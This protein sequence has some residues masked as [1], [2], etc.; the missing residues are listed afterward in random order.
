MAEGF[1]MVAGSQPTFA[2]DF[3]DEIAKL[4]VGTEITGSV[5]T[6]YDEDDADVTSTVKDADGFSTTQGR[7]RIKSTAPAGCYE[8]KMTVTLDTGDPLVDCFALVIE[9]CPEV[10]PKP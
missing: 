7:I 2:V 1:D 10:L 3:A 9:A 6:V 4:V 8:V 5:S